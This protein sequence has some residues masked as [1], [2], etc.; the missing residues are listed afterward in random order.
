MVQLC[1]KIPNAPVVYDHL[2]LTCFL[3]NPWTSWHHI[4][5]LHA[6]SRVKFF[7]WKYAHGCLPIGAYLYNIN[8]GP[9]TLSHFYGLDSEIAD[10]IL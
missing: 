3:Q 1:L 8:I 4:L 9:H 10:H 7:I 5:K 6:I 2:N